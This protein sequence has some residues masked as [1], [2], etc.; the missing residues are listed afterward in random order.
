MQIIASAIA[1]G[2]A[3]IYTD[4]TKHFAELAAGF[5]IQVLDVNSHEFQPRLPNMD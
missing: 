1:A 3:S 4:E 2:A 5:G